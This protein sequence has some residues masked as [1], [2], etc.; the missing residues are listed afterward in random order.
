MSVVS[1]AVGSSDAPQVTRVPINFKVS[2]PFL[3]SLYGIIPLCFLL[4]L[5]DYLFLGNQLRDTYLPKN[6][7]TLVIWAIVFNFPH[8]TSSLITL[9]D[10]EY[11]PFYKQRFVRALT[12][13]AVFVF[14]INIVIPLLFPGNI[15]MITTALVFAFYATYTMYHVLS[16]QFGIGMILM[17]VKSDSAA[18]ERW[19]WLATGAASFMYGMV[20]GEEYLKMIKLGEYN[21]YEIA[22]AVAAV[23]IVFATIQGYFL[24]KQSQ[25]Q[26]GTW[27]VSSNIAMLIATYVLLMMDYGFFVIAIPR[28]VH[29][30]TALTIYSVHDQNRNSV[31]KHNYIYRRLSFL[32]IPPLI[33]CTLLAIV[34]A[35]TVQCGSYLFDSWL[36]FVSVSECALS[37]FYTPSTAANPLPQTMQIWLQ[38]M[39]ICGFFHYYIEGF[40]W[41]RDSIHRH[42]I[43]FT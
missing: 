30:I 13:I 1:S 6:P 21:A 18:Y 27:Y 39:F 8:I 41:K 24:T 31:K 5:V 11:L 20:F 43:A 22:Q 37:H 17:R 32:G 42:A 3:L 23:F 7:A 38:I 29:D 36:G 4:V 26:L 2:S 34:V 19:R 25:R 16:Q 12:V 35:N 28:F 14:I 10:D 9:V 15:A 40:V 33:L